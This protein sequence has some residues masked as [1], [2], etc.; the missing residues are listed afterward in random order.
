[1]K[2]NIYDV[3]K[4]SGL[5]VVTVSRVLNDAPS[6]RE[7]NRQRV[8]KAIEELDY[9]PNS[10]A[11]SLA[12]GKTGVI[13]LTLETL[14]DTVFDGVVR[15]VNESLEEHGYF[16]ALSVHK[17]DDSQTGRQRNFLFQEDRV[18]GVMLLSPTNEDNDVLELR[19][20]RIPFVLIDNQNADVKA[21]TVNVD[22][23]K[24]GYEATKHLIELGH[25][26]IGHICGTALY[27]SAQE[28]KRGF[29]AALADAGLMP[30]AMANTEFGLRNGFDAVKAWISE[31]RVPTALFAADDFI[32]LGA[33][34]ALQDE[35]Y[36]VPSDVSVIGYDDQSFAGGIHPRLT[37]I[38]QPIKQMG[39][40]AVQLLLN[41]LNGTA[42]KNRSLLLEPEL[43]VRESTSICRVQL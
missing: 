19:K 12:R 9:R 29:E 4:K 39:V 14:E 31:K 5:S 28:R 3:A 35:G 38:R 34:Q 8:M 40:Q 32:A 33:I 24:G 30:Y 42:K 7:K 11:R 26:R 10:A 25:T 41:M 18:D 27:R 23:Y 22:N 21:T 6:V 37:T 13:G 36:R 16:L 15:T 1:M 17:E 2:V 20:K 43:V